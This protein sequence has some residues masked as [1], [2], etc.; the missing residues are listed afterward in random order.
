M[1]EVK[2]QEKK[3]NYILLAIGGKMDL[4]SSPDFRKTML[5]YIKKEQ[6]IHFILDMKEL[7]QIDSSGI[8]ALLAVY[9]SCKKRQLQIV[10]YHFSDD[11]Y[12]V[13][14]LTRLENFFPIAKN[15]E[16]AVALLKRN[17]A[18]EK[19][20]SVVKQIKV[21]SSHPLHNTEGMTHKKFNI[22]LGDVRRLSSLIAQKAPLEFQEYSI[23]EQQI[24][25]LIKNAVK[26]GNN[27]DKNKSLN[28][29]Y[30]FSA[31]SAH[32]IVKDEGPGFKD[33]EKWNQ[34]YQ[35]KIEYYRKKDFEKMMDY[36]QFRTQ[37]SDEN[38]GGN[39]LFAAI[40]YW[41]QGLIF[42]DEKNCVAVKRIFY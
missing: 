28:L 35:K 13:L 10:F 32:L 33:V 40:E 36:L 4:Y 21:D 2:V 18:N 26:H 16:Q 7:S 19:K 6:G 30:S 14:V 11:V 41:N 5:E 34:F 9:T 37:N 17:T 25:E 20:E 3:D 23:F 22:G 12:R 42:S 39:A 27:C 8:G 31:A 24:S 15:R 29:W 38:D 1:V